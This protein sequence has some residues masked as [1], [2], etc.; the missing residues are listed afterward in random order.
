MFL[1]TIIMFFNELK[2]MHF[3]TLVSFYYC[4]YNSVTYIPVNI[5]Y[6]NLHTSERF[7]CP[8]HSIYSDSVTSLN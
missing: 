2:L 1:V 5:F 6:N 3:I 8:K 4:L 7:K